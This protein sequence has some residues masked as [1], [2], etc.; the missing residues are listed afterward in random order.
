MYWLAS[1]STMQFKLLLPLPGGND[2]LLGDDHRGRQRERDVVVPAAEPLVR[3]LEGVRDQVQVGDVAVGDDVAHQGLDRIALEP[4]RALPRFG[5]LDELD[6][7][8]S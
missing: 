8:S 3:A 1:A 7:R 2:D 5:E 4:I 6:W